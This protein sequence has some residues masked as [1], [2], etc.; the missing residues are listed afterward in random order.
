MDENFKLIESKLIS[1]SQTNR[2]IVVL[3]NPIYI[4]KVV[5]LIYLCLYYLWFKP[6]DVES[7]EDYYPYH[8]NNTNVLTLDEC[9]IIK[10]KYD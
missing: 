4:N 6:K 3:I 5:S 7:K 1:N 8:L 10:G 9:N 2:E